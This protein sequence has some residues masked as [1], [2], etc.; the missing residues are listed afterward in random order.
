MQINALYRLYK[1]KHYKQNPPQK[2]GKKRCNLNLN[3]CD[4][5]CCNQ[6]LHPK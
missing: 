4:H 2:K 5:V 6:N 3:T 1:C